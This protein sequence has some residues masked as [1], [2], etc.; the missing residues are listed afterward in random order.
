MRRVEVAT[1][2]GGPAFDGAALVACREIL[3][4]VLDQVLLGQALDQVDLLDPDGSLARDGAREIDR[5]APLA[6]EQA[7]QL[8]PRDERHGDPGGAVAASELRPE[9][10]EPERA[11][12]LSAGRRRGLESELLAA[13]LEEVQVAGGRLQQH[14][15]TAG[16]VRQQ[17]VERR[18]ARNR[19][20]ELGDR[21]ELE[22]PCARLV[23]EARVLDRPGDERS[24]RD[25]EVDLRLSERPRCL[26]V[27]ADHPDHASVAR[28]DRHAEQRLEAL[29]LELGHVVDARVV[30]QVVRDERRLVALRGPPCEPASP[31][32]GD[33]ADRALVR[34][35]GSAQHQVASPS[36]R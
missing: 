31:L 29:L 35:A 19:L 34:G 2:A 4:E 18:G 16:D 12:G 14:E 17:L 9:L 23:V 26:R 8:V 1:Q 13:R 3:E 20:G 7:E 27:S 6:D 24:T 22:H 33:L 25:E 11:A 21:L 36:T 28:G 30:E 32:E 15:R 10:G 5:R